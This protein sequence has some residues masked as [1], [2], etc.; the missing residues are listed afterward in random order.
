MKMFKFLLFVGCW[1]TFSPTLLA[2][3]KPNLGG[4]T[5]VGNGG[6]GIERNG[7]FIT[8]GDANISVFPKPLEE[9][10]SLKSLMKVLKGMPFDLKSRGSMIR[11]TNPSFKRRYFAV[12]EESFDEKQFIEKYHDAIDRQVPLNTLVV[13]A[14]T[15]DYETFLLPK[16]FKLPL[17]QQTAILYHEAIWVASQELGLNLSYKEVI[18]HEI[19][20]QKY[21]S[22]N[23]EIYPF[24][25]EIFNFLGR[26][27]FGRMAIFM[28]ALEDDIRNNRLAPMIA[29]KLID[30]LHSL[31]LTN[32]L[33]NGFLEDVRFHLNNVAIL[34][35]EIFPFREMPKPAYAQNFAVPGSKDYVLA[36][37][38]RLSDKYS[39]VTFLKVLIAFHDKI[40]FFSDATYYYTAIAHR[41]G[42]GRLRLGPFTEWAEFAYG[43]LRMLNVDSE[44]EIYFLLR[45]W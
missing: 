38:A 21:L 15:K 33:G 43:G 22:T 3:R 5:G 45:D 40:T 4:N 19:S 27:V 29:D 14:F 26:K 7:R 18:D 13:Y 44:K 23:S 31:P 34:E 28:A 10:E 41:I 32:L 20:F 35:R 16:F 1:L 8:F 39:E 11:W 37:L 30:E 6:G 9:L 24:D 25:L 17:L 2:Q 12:S 36:S 42:P